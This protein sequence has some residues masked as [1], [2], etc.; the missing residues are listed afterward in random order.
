M[1]DFD[2]SQLRHLVTVQA[3]PA[4]PDQDS[5]GQPIPVFV[6]V[7]QAWAGLN[8]VSMREAFGEGQLT[9]QATDVWTMRYS[10]TPISGGMQILFGSRVFRVLAADNVEGRGILWH[11]LALEL[12]ATGAA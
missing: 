1:K 8:L 6:P 11:V 7:R 2:P 10:S 9:S 3:L 12:N 5:S 4:N